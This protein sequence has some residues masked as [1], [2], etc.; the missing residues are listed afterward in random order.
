MDAKTKIET[1]VPETV[2]NAM[3]KIYSPKRF[4]LTFLHD[5]SWNFGKNSKWKKK[6]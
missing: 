3:Q 2:F 5:E 1:E 4:Y 6:S